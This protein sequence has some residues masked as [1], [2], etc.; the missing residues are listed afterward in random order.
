M[1]TPTNNHNNAIALKTQQDADPSA[2]NAEPALF[3]TEHEMLESRRQ[4]QRRARMFGQPA[5][6]GAAST[7]NGNGAGDPEAAA[8]TDPAA[9]EPF[10]NHNS[11]DNIVFFIREAPARRHAPQPANPKTVPL[12]EAAPEQRVPARDAAAA[13]EQYT[14]PQDDIAEL[15]T[16]KQRSEATSQPGLPTAIRPIFANF[17]AELTALPNWVMWRYE[18]KSG[19]QKADKV[20]SQMNGRR[21]SSTDSST[22]VTFEACC[23]AYNRGDFDGIGFVFDGDVGDDGLCLVGIDFDHCIEDGA[24]A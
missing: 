13:P 18:Y 20:P 11:D 19:K 23:E 22:W 10:A 24:G 21:A 2:P 1:T 17:P 8:P 7:G 3:Q 9:E 14:P 12:G 4:A 5:S 15:L 16:Q 6:G